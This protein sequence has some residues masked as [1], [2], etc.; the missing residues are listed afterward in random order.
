MSD[1]GSLA[2]RL[3]DVFT[4]T[5]F[6]GN[7]LAVVLE[8]DDLTTEQM[9][10]IA[11]EFNLS[12]TTFPVAATPAAAAAGADYR[13]RIFTPGSELPFAGHPS[14]GSAW[15]MRSLG[16]VTDGA[17]VQ[18]CGA[19][20]LPLVIDG[21][22]V[23]LTGGT[24]HLG[25]AVDAA[26]IVAAVSLEQSDLV[27]DPV[28]W[29]GVGIDWAFLHVRPDALG[30]VS[31]NMAALRRLS[32]GTGVSVVSYADGVAH[33]RVL[34]GDVG[35]DPATGSAALGLG[36]WLASCGHVAAD[37]ETSYLVNQ[38]AE[39]GRP[40]QLACVVQCEAGVA[41]SVRVTG[42]VVPIGEGHIRRPQS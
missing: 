41:V 4:D 27:G 20:L 16:R 35:E 1:L 22:M 8:G 40:S 18:E 32:P 37:G 21:D 26:P 14:V 24:P 12:E 23:T 9:Q 5:A 42:S 6:M 13:L 25:E 19:G 10:T 38:G 28:R 7:Q 34:A 39:I 33:A 3:V 31:P 29:A 11:R 2:Y 17:V 15:V 30:R 36:V